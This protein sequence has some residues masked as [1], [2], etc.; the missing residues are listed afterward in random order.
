MLIGKRQ[1]FIRFA[2]CNINCKYCDTQISQ[3]GDVGDYYSVD[4]L[5][6]VVE[7]L[8]TPDFDSLEITGGEPLL[9][10][11][12]IRDFLSKYD[13]KAMLETNATLPDNLL[14]LV[15]VID[16]VSMDIKLP[17]HFNTKDEWLMVYEN[18]LKSIKIMEDNNLKYYIKIVVSPTTTIKIIEDILKDLN[19]IVGS[20]VEL[21]VQ[22][23]SP[24]SL[25]DSKKNLFTISE[26][27]GK[28]YN[29]SIIPQIHKYME[30][31]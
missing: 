8:I 15:D 18:E 9:H 28:Y 10:S 5:N 23:V 19:G 29:V 27:I 21:V 14:D 7:S 13:Y 26:E 2:G 16:I 6:K 20:D 17:E 31:E 25:W 1:I 12:Y 30:I 3:A 11:D 4:E 24:M 22:P